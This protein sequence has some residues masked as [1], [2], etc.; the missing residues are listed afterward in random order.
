[1]NKET[2]NYLLKPFLLLLAIGLIVGIIIGIHI[3]LQ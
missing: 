3:Y 2:L 1:M